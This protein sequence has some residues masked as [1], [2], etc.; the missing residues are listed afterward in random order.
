MRSQR[1]TVCPWKLTLHKEQL[2]FLLA[3][4]DNT[5]SIK[6]VY[7]IN[8][9][10]YIH[11]YSVN[12]FKFLYCGFFLK[13]LPRDQS[14]SQSSQAKSHSRGQGTILFWMVM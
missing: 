1:K 6:T 3:A 14:L 13:D 5:N 10:K 2:I 12:T 7:R 8:K 9:F 4:Q 11:T